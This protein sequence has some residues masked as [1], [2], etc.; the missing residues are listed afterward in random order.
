LELKRDLGLKSAV[1]IVM[2][3]MIGPGIFITTGALMEIT[4]SPLWILALWVAGGIIAVTGALCYAEL[5][6][7]W[8]QAGGEYLYLRNLFGFPLAFMSGWISLLAGFSASVAIS[9]ISLIDY[10]SRF[11]ESVMPLDSRAVLVLDDPAARIG[12]ASAVIIFF[13]LVHFHG[14]ILGSRVQNIFTGIKIFIALA[15]ISAGLFMA[16]WTMWQRLI[17]PFE[18]SLSGLEGPG[19]PGLGLALLIIMYSYSGWNSAAYIAAEIKDP[20][21]NIPA[22][23]IWG[24]VITAV[25]YFLLNVVFLISSPAVELVGRESIGLI[26]AKNLFGLPVSNLFALGIVFILLSSISVQMMIGP[27][28]CYAMAKDRMLPGIF[29]RVNKR[30]GTPTVAVL[31]QIILSVIYVAAGN[32]RVL[33]EYI[34]FALCIFPVLAVAGLIYSRIKFPDIVRPYRAPLFPLVPAVF[35]VLSVVML[36][37]GFTA[38]T[39]SARAALIVVLTGVPV[40]LVWKWYIGRGRRSS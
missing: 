38:D 8:P 14:V 6:A 7:I 23:L 20:G 2:A 39:F 16:D 18:S 32:A 37:A 33:M 40:Y 1:L 28:V 12:A 9:A 24:T 36:A 35:I 21:R 17:T 11:L 31:V 29:A 15:L 5:A 19:I 25:I 26:S 13:G 34:G 3:S 10:M 30:L 22:A 27:R 4:G